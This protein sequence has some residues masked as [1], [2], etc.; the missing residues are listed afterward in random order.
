MTSKPNLKTL[1]KAGGMTPEEALRVMEAMYA[2]DPSRALQSR[3]YRWLRRRMANPPTPA[4]P[5][6]EEAASPRAARRRVRKIDPI[7]PHSIL[8]ETG[9]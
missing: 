2:D 7:E 6:T 4:V 5:P 3:T 9:G 1:V 8:G